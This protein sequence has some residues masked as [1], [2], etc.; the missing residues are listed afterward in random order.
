MILQR[1]TTG[2]R[3]STPKL[4]RRPRPFTASLWFACASATSSWVR[5][6][7]GGRRG[8]RVNGSLATPSPR[9]LASFQHVDV[10]CGEYNTPTFGIVDTCVDAAAWPYLPPFRARAVLI[11]LPLFRG[12][13]DMLVPPAVHKSIVAK[14]KPHLPPG[15]ASKADS[16]FNVGNFFFFGGGGGGTATAVH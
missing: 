11:P 16:F 6:C 14:L 4:S 3:I 12:T 8:R 5:D 7:R 10:E 9:C 13:T 1:R 2:A 15:M